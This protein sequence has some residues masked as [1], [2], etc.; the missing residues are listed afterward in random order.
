MI[1]KFVTVAPLLALLVGCATVDARD[2][3]DESEA[4][5]IRAMPVD[6]KN[7]IIG[8][9]KDIL[10]DPYSIRSAEISPPQYG[11]VGLTG[12]GNAAFVCV[13]FNSRNAFGGYT[14]V[15]THV[16]AWQR[17]HFEGV[18]ENPIS[19]NDHVVYRPFPELENLK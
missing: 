18:F 9:L 5:Q 13:R 8:R 6:Y 11:W 12:G 1:K 14:G 3:T 10:R 2:I 4:D 7:V 17:G 16:A 19:C 15:Q